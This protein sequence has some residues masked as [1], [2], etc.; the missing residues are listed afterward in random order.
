[1]VIYV[2]RLVLHNLN[3]FWCLNFRAEKEREKILLF[4]IPYK[5]NE[6]KKGKKEKRKRRNTNFEL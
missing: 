1:V 6:A 3:V 2:S 4:C 5:C